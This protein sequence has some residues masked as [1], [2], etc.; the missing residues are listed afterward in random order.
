MIPVTGGIDIRGD[1]ATVGAY[2]GH[3]P[4]LTEWTTFFQAVD[5]EKD[6]RFQVQSVMG[7]IETWITGTESAGARRYVIHSLIRGQEE[8]AELDLQEHAEHVAVRFTVNL[9]P[10]VD[11]DVVV[12]QRN[13]M[14][15]ELVQ[16][17]R[18]LEAS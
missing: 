5:G 18:L 17:K 8:E 10:H 1:L 12:G 4:N 13:E 16:L 7:P 3:M 15:E 9:P 6:G 14:A 2:L 11:E